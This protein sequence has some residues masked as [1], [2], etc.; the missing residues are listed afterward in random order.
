MGSFEFNRSVVVLSKNLKPYAINLTKDPDDAKDL[1]QETVYR[2]LMNK[3]KYAE[4]TNLKAWLF[5]IMRNIFINSYRR[6]AK[7]NTIADS[8]DNLFY[9]NS[10]KQTVLNGSEASF[11]MQNAFSAIEKLSDDYKVPF[12]MHYEGFKYQEIANDLQLPLGTVKSRIF[13]ARKE[14]KKE[15]D[16]YKHLG[17]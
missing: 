3:E 13:F 9:L 8:T 4:G 5:T 1:I 6:K 7:Q 16:V 2:A 11:V 14:L 12:M 10:G 17:G 15:L